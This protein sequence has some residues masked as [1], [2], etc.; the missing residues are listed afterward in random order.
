MKDAIF[1]VFASIALLLLVLSCYPHFRTGN[2]GAIALVAWCFASNFVYLVDCLIYWDT[3]ENLT[4]VWCDIMVKIQA[5]TQTGLAA[6]CLCINRRLAIISC[7]KQTSAT[8]KSRRWAFWSDIMICVLAPVIV[9]VVSY[10][11]QSHRYNIVENFGCSGSP[12]MDVYAILGLHGSPVLLGAISFVY[13][14]IAIYNFI[15]QRRRFQVVLQQNSSLNTSRFVRLIGVAGVNIVISLLFAIRETVLTAHSVYPTVSWDYI[16]YD[17]DLVFTYDSFFLLG[18]PQAWVELN[19]SRWLPCVASFIYFAFFG[20][21]EDMLSYYTYVWARL[22]QALL[23]TKERIFGQPLT[24]HDPSQY[25][26]LGT[27]VASPSECG[28]SQD[29]ISDEEQV[30]PHSRTEISEKSNIDEG[31]LPRFEKICL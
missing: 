4:P 19:L 15:A 28:W 21:H 22:S 3:V 17:F 24:V 5:T 29:K 25:P 2:I 8:S 20:M 10:C 1:P 11:V 23:R 14:A 31:S 26:K 27:A 18:D 9:A 13:G 16:H 12:W 7:S 6:A 30:F